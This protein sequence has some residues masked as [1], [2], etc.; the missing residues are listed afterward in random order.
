MWTLSH[1]REMVLQGSRGVKLWFTPLWFGVFGVTSAH[2]GTGVDF[3]QCPTTAKATQIH[4]Y[5][6]LKMLISW[7][8]L[9]VYV[10]LKLE[11]FKL[12]DS[13]G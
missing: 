12:I 3:Y 7:E 5:G 4:N 8:L 1:T 10:E 9:L 11:M 13:R 6:N 2:K